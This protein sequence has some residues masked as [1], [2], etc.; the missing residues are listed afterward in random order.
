MI[1]NKEQ[2]III[3]HFINNKNGKRIL[4]VEAPPGT[5]KTY[6]AVSTA[7]HYIRSNMKQDSKYNK[8][9][10]ILTFSKNAKA[11]IE[12]QLDDLDISNEG[13]GKYIEITNFHSFFQKYVW[14][15]NKYLGLNEN[16][17]IASP[18]Q[19][20]K[21]LT[22]KLS[23]ISDYSGEDDDQYGWVESLLEGEFYPLTHKG[24]IKPAV[25]RLIPYKENIKNSI[26]ELNKDGYIG[27]SDIGYY[28][29]ELLNKSSS[30]LK[31]IQNKYDMII[32]DEY[33]DASDLQDEIVKKLIGEKNKA[34]FFADSK[35]MI[36]GWRGASPNRIIDLLKEYGNEIEQKA[37][38]TSMRFKNQ[39]DIEGLIKNARQE[40]Y[41]INGFKSSENVKHIK[42]K[43]K[44]KNLFS[45]QS[46]NSMYASLKFKIIDILPKYEKRK[47]KSIGIL[48][49]YNEQVDFIKKALREDFKISSQ[50]ISNNEEEHNIVC[51]LIE[52]LEKQRKD[53]SKDEL[54]KEIAKYIFSVIYDDNIGAIKRT[55]LDEVKFANFKNARLSLLKEIA[56]FIEE[57]QE[58]K[59]FLD[60]L[61]RS[62]N[63]VKNGQLNVNHENLYLVRKILSSKKSTPEKI[64]DLFL[65]YQY[66]KAFKDLKGIY[67]LNVHQS[68][69]REFD[70]V[71]LVDTETM[72]KESNLLY[73]A[74]SRVKEK[75]VI[76]DWII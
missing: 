33:Q 76:F 62:I 74:L 41:D 14:A 35:Q 73:V 30:L 9:V 3:N 6:T 24:N 5:G 21:L 71:Y 19:R 17:M 61:V 15:Y 8:K 72:S 66:L 38:V 34:I 39:K 49:R 22:E 43:V 10:L 44:D 32:L 27:F 31:V 70:F 57:A 18:K 47:D 54:S 64:T 68:K 46:K 55:K 26:K 50:T 56:S 53:L 16:L 63:T 23:Y 28:M 45:K 60:C 11:Q 25:K 40:T 36:Y 4:L 37:L 52:F 58:S 1:P 20:R 12:K 2:E 13:L 69:G 48:C 7:L 59:D 65:Q 75:L 42:I 51:D 29:K 67:V